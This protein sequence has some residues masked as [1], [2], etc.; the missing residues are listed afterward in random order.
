MPD[1]LFSSFLKNL[2]SLL[3]SLCCLN[4]R[5]LVSSFLFQNIYNQLIETNNN[6]DWAEIPS[7]SLRTK[8]PASRL[9]KSV[10][11]WTK[12]RKRFWENY[13]F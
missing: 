10:H 8:C 7:V 4:W 6:I 9:L 3:R 13:R 5:R 11:F 1:E 2:I 12:K